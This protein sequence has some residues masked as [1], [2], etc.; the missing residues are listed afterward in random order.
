MNNLIA[1]V[2]QDVGIDDLP[3]VV[4]EVFDNGKRDTV[5]EAIGAVADGAEN[6][7]LVSSSGTKTWDEGTH[8]DAA[9]Q[10]LLGQRYAEAIQ[11]IITEND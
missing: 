11:S 3:V 6:V 8:F 4:G 7:A 9:S 1:R 10:L 2:R 5:R